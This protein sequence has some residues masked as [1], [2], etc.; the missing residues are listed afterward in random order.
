MQEDGYQRPVTTFF[1]RI[2]HVLRANNGTIIYF[3]WILQIGE[4][5]PIIGVAR[6]LHEKGQACKSFILN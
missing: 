4:N 5:R 2:P 6:G 3:I 1:K